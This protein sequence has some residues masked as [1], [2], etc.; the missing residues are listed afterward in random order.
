VHLTNMGSLPPP[1]NQERMN[2]DHKLEPVLLIATDQALYLCEWKL[3]PPD[4]RMAA[5]AKKRN[6]KLPEERQLLLL[7]RTLLTQ[8]ESMQL[9]HLADDCVLIMFKPQEKMKTPDKSNWV[10]ASSVKRCMETQ[11]PFSFFGKSRHQCAYTGG[12]YVKDVMVKVIFEFFSTFA[13]KRLLRH[14]ARLLNPSSS[15]KL[16]NAHR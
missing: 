3:V 11:E 16:K 10:A 9:S 12:V 13:H 8:I 7:R 1:R 2:S 5:E 6:Q 14:S 4:P 15:T